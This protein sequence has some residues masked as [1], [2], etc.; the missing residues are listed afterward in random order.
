LTAAR[1]ASGEG[2]VATAVD[3]VADVAARMAADDAPA[4]RR[5]SRRGVLR[6]VSQFEFS[7]TN[8]ICLS[9]RSIGVT[10]PY[11]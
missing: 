6:A 4:G 8:S 9:A 2:L 5:A 10:R 3:A 7:G 1:S 11:T